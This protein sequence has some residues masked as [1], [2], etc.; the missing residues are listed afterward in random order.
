MELTKL[1][2]TGQDRT[3]HF[4]YNTLIGDERGKQMENQELKYQVDT[5]MMQYKK[6]WGI[7]YSLAESLLQ[8]HIPF[9]VDGKTMIF[10]HGLEFSLDK[11]CL[12]F[13]WNDEEVVRDFFRYERA[14]EH[15]ANGFKFFDAKYKGI[16]IRCMFY[17]GCPGEDSDEFLYRNTDLVKINDFIIPVQS[18]EFYYENADKNSMHYKMVEGWLNRHERL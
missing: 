11:I 14:A 8:H 5:S 1:N 17:G 9:K 7:L 4:D 3:L 15:T 13:R 16:K 10:A 2:C 18:L 12:T 6:E